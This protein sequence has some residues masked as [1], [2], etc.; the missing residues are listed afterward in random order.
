MGVRTRRPD[1]APYPRREEASRAAESGYGPFLAKG[2]ASMIY[3]AEDDHVIYKLTSL[4]LPD[5]V[6]YLRSGGCCPFL[7][8]IR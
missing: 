8:G 4:Y 5:L 2:L 1:I 7:V 6:K 3:S